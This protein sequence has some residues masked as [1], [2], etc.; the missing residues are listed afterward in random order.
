M[1]RGDVVSRVQESDSVAVASRKDRQKVRQRGV[2]VE[3]C[4]T[5][6]VENG[7]RVSKRGPPKEQVRAESDP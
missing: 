1:A 5:A 2:P 4:K 3:E 7:G 6:S